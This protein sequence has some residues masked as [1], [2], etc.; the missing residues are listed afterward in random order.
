[1]ERKRD[2][3][4]YVLSYRDGISVHK[5]EE[6]SHLI[7]KKVTTH[8]FFLEASVIYCYVDYRNEVGT[9]SIIRKAWELGKRVAVPKVDGEQMNF[10]Y[11]SDFTDLREGYRKILEP[12]VRFPANDTH[13][14]VI[15]PGVAFDRNRNRIGYGKGFYDK[16]MDKHLGFQ[17]IAIAFECQIIDAIAVDSFDYRPD[18]LITEEQIYDKDIA[19]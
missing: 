2:I 1:M 10:Y 12:D 4:K 7:Y 9:E 14:L 6:N 3:R 11:I 18:V 13:A 16:F 19:N 15:M 5:W 17:T 8:P